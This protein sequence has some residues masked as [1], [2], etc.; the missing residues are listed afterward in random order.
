VLALFSQSFNRSAELYPKRAEDPAR[1][2]RGRLHGETKPVQEMRW[3]CIDTCIIASCMQWPPE[4]G[5][6]T[7][8]RDGRQVDV[9]DAALRL[10]LIRQSP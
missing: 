3:F 1:E 4:L 2:Q 8:K 10:E 6:L 9:G 7:R 5:M